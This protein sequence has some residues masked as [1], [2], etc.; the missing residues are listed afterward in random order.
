M[1]TYKIE[2]AIADLQAVER[3]IEDLR[4]ERE[5]LRLE[6]IKLDGSSD[7]DDIARRAAL[8][9]AMGRVG[10]KLPA[11]SYPAGAERPVTAV[12]GSM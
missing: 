12:D 10:D 5:S 8:L 3:E 4:K 11:R 9:E 2:Q 7:P 6:A 1:A